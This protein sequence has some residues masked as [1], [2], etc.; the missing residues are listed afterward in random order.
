VSYQP[1]KK[2]G[3]S[4]KQ[5]IIIS[6][7]VFTLISMI[8][9]SG[10][11]IG[12]IFLIG[13]NTTQKSTAALKEQIQTNILTTAENNGDIVVSKLENSAAKV[14]MLT[15]QLIEL[16][17]TSLNYNYRPSYYN[18]LTNPPDA[19]YEEEYGFN[20]SWNYSNFDF[21]GANAS[22]WETLAA[23][24]PVIDDTINRSAHLDYVFQ[25]IHETSPEFRWLYTGFENCG[26]FRNYPGS[27]F[28]NIKDARTRDWYIEAKAAYN[29]D[30]LGEQEIIYIEPY[31]DISD[32]SLLISVIKAAVHNN[33]LIGVAAGD[34]TIETI[35]EQILDIE[36]LESG[37][38]TMVQ[39]DNAVVVAHPDWEGSATNDTIP[40]LNEFEPLTSSQINQ[41]TSGNSGVIEYTRNGEQWYLAYVPIL[42]GEYTISVLVPLDEAIESVSTLEAQID[43]S[44]TITIIEVAIIVAVTALLA[45]FVG[46]LTSNRIVKPIEK[47]TQIASRMSTDTIR[48]DLAKGIDLEIDEELEE[49][50]D[51][52]G[53][54]TRA[55]K[56]MIQSIKEESENDQ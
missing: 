45:L 53:D 46:I 42:G 26:L 4:I 21:P 38:A 2:K 29:L 13:N 14:E 17:T 48:E 16:M 23:A 9:V 22:N 19:Q 35:Q 41:I 50:D 24:D 40:Y 54:L 3:R 44:T 28:E 37:F 56:G 25:M 49:Q 39:G 51:E 43:R 11:S 18:N 32:G 6:F 1:P 27:Y 47:L 10:T 33:I 12:F 8:V 31:Y 55:F 7:I 15:Q 36:I 5:Q 52:I 34:I 20:V 30:P